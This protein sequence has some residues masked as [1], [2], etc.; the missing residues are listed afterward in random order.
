MVR[1]RWFRDMVFFMWLVFAGVV[2]RD[3]AMSGKEN[4]FAGSCLS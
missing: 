1:E 4:G 2:D 3:E